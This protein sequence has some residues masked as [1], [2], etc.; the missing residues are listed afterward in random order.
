MVNLRNILVH[1]YAEIDAKRV[2]GILT[3]RLKDFSL[4]SSA[5]VNFLEKN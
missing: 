4:F 5:V 3:K 2:H 1:D